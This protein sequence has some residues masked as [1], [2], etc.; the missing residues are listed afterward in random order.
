MRLKNPA[1]TSARIINA[2]IFF[3]MLLVDYSTSLSAAAITLREVESI[4]PPSAATDSMNLQ[5]SE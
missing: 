4:Q 3:M 2:M 5:G 1:A